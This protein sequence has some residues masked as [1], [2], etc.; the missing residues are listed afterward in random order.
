MSSMLCST[1]TGYVIEI[2]YE[3]QISFVTSSCFS[4]RQWLQACVRKNADTPCHSNL[5]TLPLVTHLIVALCSRGIEGT[6]PKSTTLQQMSD[7]HQ[8]FQPLKDG[9]RKQPRYLP[10][11]AHM[12]DGRA[13]PES[14]QGQNNRTEHARHAKRK[15]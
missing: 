13:K 4:L 11:A 12:F 6:V 15:T 14:P 2:A 5:C 1:C 3:Q 10:P 7:H 9:Q 8:M